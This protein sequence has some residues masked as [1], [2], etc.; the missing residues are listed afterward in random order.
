MLG[1]VI[2]LPIIV[3]ASPV[4][5]WII[6]FKQASQN[7]DRA[8]IESIS[9]TE[10]RGRNQVE[11]L[12]IDVAPA[13]KFTNSLT[14]SSHI[15]EGLDEEAVQRL[16]QDTRVEFIEENERRYPIKSLRVA[17]VVSVQ[18]DKT[19]TLK[20][21]TLTGIQDHYVS[22]LWNLD[23]ADAGGARFGSAWATNNGEDQ[24][25]AVLDT[26]VTDHPDLGTLSSASGI[27]VSTGYTFISD[28]RLAGT[29]NPSTADNISTQNP[30]N[31]AYDLGD[32]VKTTD[33]QYDVFKDCAVEPN[34]WHGTHLSG[35]VAAMPNTIGLVGA[36]YG[37]RVLPVRVIGKCGAQVSDIANA[38]RWAVG[39]SVSGASINPYPSKIIGL[40][41]GSYGSCSRAEQEA[42][43]DATSAGAVIVVAAG[44]E[45]V[46]TDVRAVT[47]TNCQN[48]IAVTAHSRLGLHASYANTGRVV[49]ISAPGGDFENPNNRTDTTGW[50]LSSWNTGTYTLGSGTYAY[51]IGTSQ[52]VPHVLSAIALL[53][54]S[55]PDITVSEIKKA[56]KTSARPFLAEDTTCQVAGRCGAGMLDAEAALITA[57]AIIANRGQE[58]AAEV[59][60]QSSSSGGGGCTL[61]KG[62]D[63][64]LVLPVL[65]LVALRIRRK[66]RSS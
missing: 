65:L 13:M 10:R 64:T 60:N 44:N 33:V 63:H 39:L 7:Q 52:A 41:L 28:C 20:I 12:G 35:I 3:F 56:L 59:T 26:G 50:I 55:Y 24:I 5:N 42:I 45:G 37:A 1:V 32:G 19:P 17:S 62:S 23:N 34:S 40:S 9:V 36:S 18:E 58:V 29:C 57:Q 49:S 22:S 48:V 21:Q 8:H 30:I 11:Q 14:K 53:R 61:G 2:S 51:E 46:N 54:K 15:V 47:P 43:N 31:N 6:H 38:I 25:I 66:K 27:W 4:K 16:R